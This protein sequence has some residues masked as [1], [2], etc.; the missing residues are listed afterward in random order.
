MIRVSFSP[1]NVHLQDLA[2]TA[3]RAKISTGDP[4]RDI[5]SFSVATEL[6]ARVRLA[7]T[8]DVAARALL[9]GCSSIAQ[10]FNCHC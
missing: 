7:E 4:G 5:H 8:T 1:V 2:E 3:E 6:I 10:V 9:D